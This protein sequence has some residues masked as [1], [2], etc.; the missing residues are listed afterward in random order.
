M[1]LFL[2][3]LR[4]LIYVF[5]NPVLFKTFL[6][7][8]VL[9]T[10]QHSYVLNKNYK[11]LVDIG[12]NRGQFSLAASLNSDT[13]I[14][15]FEPLSVPF[16]IFRKIFQNNNKVKIFQAAIGPSVKEE[17]MH[18]SAKDDSSSLFKISSLQNELFPGTNEVGLEKVPIAPL[19]HFI[20][21]KE[22][23]SPA[24]L[25]LDVQG[26]ELEA[27]TGCQ[28]LFHKFDQIYCECSFISLY[29]GQ[30]LS[31]EIIS[32]LKTHNYD[33]IGF[34]NLKQTHDG[35]CIQAD[36]LFEYRSNQITKV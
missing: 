25:K 19:D 20:S 33:L 8:R 23:L 7:H 2:L 4:K 26:S 31:S 22:I 28:S 11:T 27:L 1:R 29:E 34:Y 36:L 16:S 3:R 5:T 17:M 30:K 21:S 24:L 32:Y 35:A 10:F 9:A 14:F 18:I 15:A 13:Y 12:A 6:K